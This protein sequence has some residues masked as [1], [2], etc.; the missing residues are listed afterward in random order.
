MTNPVTEYIDTSNVISPI[1]T[2]KDMVTE[3]VFPQDFTKVNRF[4]YKAPRAEDIYQEE[5]LKLEALRQHTIGADRA[6][7]KNTVKMTPMIGGNNP[8]MNFGAAHN[9]TN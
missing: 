7:P 8:L 5:L 3:R 4:L 6:N 2:T 9:L 1:K